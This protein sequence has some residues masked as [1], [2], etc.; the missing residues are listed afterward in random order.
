MLGGGTLLGLALTLRALIPA[1]APKFSNPG[2]VDA[3]FDS[4]FA[5]TCARL[6]LFVA[7]IYL[8]V[9]MVA[10]IVRRRWLVEAGPFKTSG[11]DEAVATLK[12]RTRRPRSVVDDGN[13]SDR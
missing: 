11:V 9:S 7:T 4:R 1:D 3:V 12:H 8:I 13:R 6:V 10:L 2:F 5:I